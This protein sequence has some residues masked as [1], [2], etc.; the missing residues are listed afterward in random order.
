MMT[1][2]DF[3]EHGFSIV[4][5][6]DPTFA[7]ELEQLGPSIGASA[8]NVGPDYCLVK[9][10]SRQSIVAFGVRFTKRSADGHMANSDVLASQ[11]S[12]LLDLGQRGRY[13]RP[14]EGLVMPGAARLVTPDGIVDPAGGVYTSYRTAPPWTTIKVQVDS[15]VFD[16]GHA[17]G[18]DQLGAIKG[19]RA[20]VDAQQDLMEEI[21]DKLSHGGSFR[22]VLNELRGA[23]LSNG[24]PKAPTRLDPSQIYA[25]VRLQYLNEL[26]TTE[27]NGG[28]EFAQRRL[29]QLKYAT[30]PNIYVEQGEN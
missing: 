6:D 17:I 3:S 20:H 10:T 30:R 26:T 4:L 28:E 18:P 11:P 27:A 7:E 25:S 21:S 9:N 13:D 29:R 12:A 22:S 23:A 16:D 5:S 14:L 2:Q 19:L 15:V 24:E 1:K 8:G